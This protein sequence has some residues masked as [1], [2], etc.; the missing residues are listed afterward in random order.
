MKRISVILVIALLAGIAGGC[1]F[2]VVEDDPIRAGF[3]GALAEGATLFNVEDPDFSFL[4]DEQPY[5]PEVSPTATPTLTPRPTK[6][7]R[8]KVTPIPTPVPT[9]TVAAPMDQPIAVDEALEPSAP[10]EA[11]LTVVETPVPASTEAGDAGESS[12]EVLIGLHSRD[13]EGESGVRKLQERLVALGYLDAEADGIFGSRTLKALMRFQKER[14]LEETG[15]LDRATKNALFPAPTVTTAPEDVMYTEGA[16]GRD[17][18][19]LHQRLRQY[20]FSTRLIT[21]RYDEDTAEEVMAFQQ[22]AVEHYGTEFDDPMTAE[23]QDYSD[24]TTVA[25]DAFGIPEMPALAP[26][27]TLR[28]HHAVDGVVSENLYEYLAS[29][30]FPVYRLTV[31]RGD[32]G[33]EVE[34]VQRRLTTLEFFY[35]DITGEYDESTTEALKSFQARNDLQKTG[36]ADAETQQCLF[37]E[38]ALAAEQVEMPYYIKVS[39]DDQRVYI[40]RWSD[41]GYNQLIKTMICSTGLGN[42]TPRGVYV[43]PGQ[44]DARWHYFAEFHCWAQ[45]AFIITGNILFHSVIYSAK[46]EDSVRY[47]TISNLGHKASH[48]CVRLRVP[49]AQWIYENCRSGQVIEVY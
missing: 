1:R 2:A 19:T 5:E 4:N 47:S 22:Y 18:R 16:V 35:N 33:E 21:A 7:P 42:S 38:A 27:A 8:V 29:D 34:R 10:A 9:P 17:I 36:I 48:G 23:I 40:Y 39:I 14:G 30:R 31:Q 37:S 46:S 12:G 43:S 28:P 44:R 3:G 25:I 15:V 11:G 6:M 41:G 45:Y 26:E 24:V 20:G 49:D 32:F 13:E